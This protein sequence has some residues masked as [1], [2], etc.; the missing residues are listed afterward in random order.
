M[1]SYS[2]NS[3]AIDRSFATQQ[4]PFSFP[5]GTSR[6]NEADRITNVAAIAAFLHP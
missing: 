4:C 1:I 2:I 3:K 6:T 5:G